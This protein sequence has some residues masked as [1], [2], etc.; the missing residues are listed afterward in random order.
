LTAMR[1]QAGD[2]GNA[3]NQIDLNYRV[4]G[5]AAIAPSSPPLSIFLCL[6]F[7]LSF[8]CLFE[9]ACAL[10]SLPPLTSFPSLPVYVYS[11]FYRFVCLYSCAL[12]ILVPPPPPPPSPFPCNA[13]EHGGH[14]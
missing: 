5:L 11:R 2:K 12:A 6:Y 1:K 13:G 10:P 14:V 8:A 9:V 4:L 7:D 3:V